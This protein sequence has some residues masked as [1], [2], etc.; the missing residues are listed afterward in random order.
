MSQYVAGSTTVASCNGLSWIFCLL[1]W[2]RWRHQL[3]FKKRIRLA[4]IV[5]KV[6]YSIIR[7]G[8]AGEVCT[9]LATPAQS[10]RFDGRPIHG[11]A[12]AA[13]CSSTQVALC[14]CLRCLRGLF[15]RITA[16]RL[17]G[18]ACK[19]PLCWGKTDRH[20]IWPSVALI[21][22][23]YLKILLLP[24]RIHNNSVVQHLDYWYT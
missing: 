11:C 19:L 23:K 1:T 7:C 10:S 8:P 13:R 14:E 6:V 4:P 9:P 15:S 2:Q 17:C 20:A 22:S 5:R 3:V 24:H 18:A 16:Q 12:V 21:S